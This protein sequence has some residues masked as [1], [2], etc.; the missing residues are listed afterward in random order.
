MNEALV[1]SAL[2][3]GFVG[4]T[5]CVA[6]CG[7]VVT[8]LSGGLVQLGRKPSDV[9]GH[10]AIALVYNAGR[11]LSYSLAGA[12]AGGLGALL[13][14]I[15]LLHS[16]ELGLRLCA[17][18]L[19]LGLGLYLAGGWARFASIERLGLPLWRGIEPV[20]RRFLPARSLRG[21]FVLGGLWGFM[22]CG[23]VYT[24]LALSLGNTS[25]FG[26]AMTMAAF[27]LGTLPAL[28]TLGVFAS[29]FVGV[30]VT[31]VA[32]VRRLAGAVVIAFGLFH[33]S[34]ALSAMLDP[35]ATG[36]TCG[37]HATHQRR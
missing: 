20:A 13:A 28:L 2:L 23:L 26:G 4:S 6:M 25:A 35:A 15:P 16:A 11:I 8:A 17:G 27:G 21:A 37:A 14:T 34:S 9:E 12:M 29:R 19:M 32:W 18:L 33:A 7:G 30:G 24:A 5:H 31:R 22:P 1:L 3:M 36:N 10:A